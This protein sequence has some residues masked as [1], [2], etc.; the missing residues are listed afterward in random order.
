MFRAHGLGKGDIVMTTLRNRYEY[1]IAAVALHKLGA[2]LLPA[3]HQLTKKDIAYR[4]EAAG[5]KAIVTDG[6]PRLVQCIDEAAA[7]SSFLK[8]KFIVE[9][10]SEGYIDFDAAIAESSRMYSPAPPETRPP[11]TTTCSSCIS[12]P[13]RPA[14][15]RSPCTITAIRSDIF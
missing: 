8:L 9:G 10:E 2:V 5:V 4:I 1:W 15:P 7:Y 13:A 6:E 12:H 14:C 3:T 11:P